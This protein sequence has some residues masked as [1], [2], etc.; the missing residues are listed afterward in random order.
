MRQPWRKPRPDGL[1][2]VRAGRSRRAGAGSGG[3]DLVGQDL[4]RR[5]LPDEIEPQHDLQPA[6]PLRHDALQSSQR[7]HPVIILD[8]AH[9]RSVPHALIDPLRILVSAQLDSVCLAS[10]LLIGQPDLKLLLRH[11]AHAAFDQRVT[12]RYAF[13]P[14]SLADTQ[15][16]IKHHLAIAGFKAPNLFSDEALIRIFDVTKGVPRLIN[17]L[18][19]TALMA[20]AIDQ[21]LIIDEPIIRRAIADL[22]QG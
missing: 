15:A 20:A 19:L 7:R 17:Q 21:K 6:L 16:Y 10:L 2:R 14:L 11:P 8:E 1:I 5:R 13:E 18:C 3:L 4:H 12:V 22:D 9:S